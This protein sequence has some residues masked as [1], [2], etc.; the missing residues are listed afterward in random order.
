MIRFDLTVVRHGETNDNLARILSGQTNTPL[1]QT[2]D[3]QATAAGKQLADD[4][5]DIVL[6]S[7][8]IRAARTATLILE[9]NNHH[10]TAKRN[11][12]KAGKNVRVLNS[13]QVTMSNAV[14]F[15]ND[16][17]LE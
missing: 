13:V 5:F 2:G 10:P 11:D 9:Q 7:D 1:N 12:E 14:V 17:V 16:Y 15:L 4:S 6:S 8:L 3:S